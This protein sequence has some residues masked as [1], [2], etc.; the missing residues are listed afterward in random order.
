M[1]NIIW[2]GEG[3]WN[4]WMLATDQSSKND[5][6]PLLISPDGTAYGP[7]NIIS[8][9]DIY[10]GP[11]AAAKWGVGESTVRNYA[12]QGKFLPNEII[13]LKRDWGITRQGMV[14]LFGNPK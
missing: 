1:D 2:K 9:D 8:L 3:V 6:Q 13:R 4:G 11:I 12:A 7:N 10:S 5:G 14:R